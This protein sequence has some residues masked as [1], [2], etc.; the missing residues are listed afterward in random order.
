MILCSVSGHS[1]TII[2]HYLRVYSHIF[3]NF[4]IPGIFRNLVYSKVRRYLDPCQTYCSV[5]V[6]DSFSCNYYYFFL[7]APS[8][9][10][11]NT[12]HDLKCAD[13]SIRATW[14]AH[15]FQ[16]YLDISRHYS[17]TCSRIFRILFISD[18][19][20]TLVYSYQKAYSDSK[21]YS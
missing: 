19:F 6:E 12:C 8:R 20:R 15:L 3:R 10:I 14:L 9:T 17:R 21:A 1:Q 16:A 7:N 11:F 5:F 2:K 18:I 13:L 4:S